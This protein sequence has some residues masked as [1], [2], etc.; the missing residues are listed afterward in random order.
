M[1]RRVFLLTRGS[2]SINGSIKS[3]SI[4]N[5]RISTRNYSDS[6]LSDWAVYAKKFC[7]NDHMDCKCLQHLE[8]RNDSLLDLLPW[9]SLWYIHV[10]ESNRIEDLLHAERWLNVFQ[11]T[12][13]R[14]ITTSEGIVNDNQGEGPYGNCG[15]YCCKTIE[16]EPTV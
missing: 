4:I 5:S 9:H 16:S 7:K 8:T 12:I 1:L 2:S 3:S 6:E 13:K 11:P 15:K 10:H 14:D